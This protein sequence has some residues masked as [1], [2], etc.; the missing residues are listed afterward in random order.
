MKRKTVIGLS[1]TDKQPRISSFFSQ[2][3]HV[4]EKRPHSPIDLTL[5][6]SE[7]DRQPPIKKLKV[8]KGISPTDQWR[9]DSTQKP[10]IERPVA[11]NEDK[12]RRHAEF[13]RVLLAGNN[14]FARQ[15]R[16]GDQGDQLSENESLQGQNDD[17]ASAE[18]DVSD[19][20]FKNL[21]EMFSRKPN[22]AKGKT[23]LAPSA[24]CKGTSEGFGPSGQP[25]TP[26]ELQA[27]LTLLTVCMLIF[28]NVLVQPVAEV[29]QRSPRG[30]TIPVHRRDVHLKKLLSQGH[31]VGIVEQME[32]AALK[33]ASETRNTLFER[34]LTHLYTATTYVDELESADDL[35]KYAAP[36]L[37][38]FT[39]VSE[40]GGTS[41]D[42][43]S[44][45]MIAI[46]PSTG[47][48]VWDEFE[49]E[50]RAHLISLL[51][52]RKGLDTIMR[53]ELETRLVHTR[54]AELVLPEQGLSKL[55]EKVLRHFAGSVHS[56]QKIR[57]ERYKN[58]MKFSVAFDFV[59]EFYSDRTK[60]NSEDLSMDG[61]LGVIASLPQQVVVSL[62]HTINYL[63]S[64]HIADAFLGARYFTKFANRTH[65]LLNASTLANLF[66]PCP[67]LK[68]SLTGPCREVYQNQTDY[69]AKGSL[70]W[71][72]DRTTTKFGARLLKSWVGQPLTD[73]RL[74][75]DRIDA[76]EEIVTS[77]SEK[78]VALR[79]V[80][81]KLP[82]LAKGLC[83]IQYGKCS[84]QELAI[85]L[86]ALKRVATA[87]DGFE[88][89]SL[90]DF[91]SKLLNEIVLS[92]PKLKSP[93]RE[94]LNAISLK[95]AAE[96]KKESLWTD[97]Q[98]FPAL[99]EHA[100][101]IQT[102]ETEL[103]EELKR[104]RKILRMPSLQWTSVLGIEFL[105]EVKK[106][107]NRDH[108]VS[109]DLVS[110]T[111]YCRRYHTPEVKKLI[112]ERARYKE[113]LAAEANKAYSAFLSEIAQSHYSLLRDAINKLAIADCLLS[114]AH[115]ALQDG[116]VRPELTDEDVLDIIDGRHPMV[117]ALRSDPFVP[118]SLLMGDDSPRSII[119]TGPN[120]GG[121]SSAVRMVALI[122]IM[123]QIGSYVPARA[124]K[125][126]M[127]D[128]IITRMGASDELAR[129]RSTFM[130]EMAE[131]NEILKT[132][133]SNSLVILDELGR[134][135]STADGMAIA[136][137]VLQHLVENI[138]SKTL[139]I[140]H[141]PLVAVDLERRFPDDVQNLHMGYTTDNRIDGRR[142][143]TFL[144]Q[145]TD[146][147]AEESFGVECARLAGIPEH[148]L[149]V[150]TERSE[151]CRT[152]IESRSRLNKARR[153]AQLVEQCLTK[154]DVTALQ[155]LHTRITSSPLA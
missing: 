151:A 90:G 76:I 92:L 115:I 39:E 35:D 131:T 106:S 67:L 127:C 18:S 128:A 2:Q 86:P 103:E 130:V 28:T 105:V 79:Q 6:D 100:L 24:K 41:E 53:S 14:N 144:Y 143:V 124:A 146:G 46:T 9:F 121:K 78:L 139:F 132:A 150:A 36:P 5:E 47:D 65:M 29:Y 59:T 72:L 62:A 82:D 22:K 1:G 63:S 21:T 153:C 17:D 23:R 30:T 69:T 129:G 3:P 97:T 125:V 98:R 40:S 155:A 84:P 16:H 50:F 15:R 64:F 141:Y 42:H 11:V 89:S 81:K 137:A 26:A 138:R 25:Y 34:K 126:G 13:K 55:T 49:G 111:K 107:A 66:V 61:I 91:H 10:S 93:V 44:I 149:S 118:N 4:Q 102:V 73:K 135:T 148:I 83:R 43:V 113:L 147:F 31:K 38:C 12:K 104:I 27:S 109:W 99:A 96:G 85:L 7:V 48:V 75:Q 142:D 133:T 33:K 37:V 136:D 71:V 116:Y 123:A 68:S 154:G 87:F 112:Q 101:M 140:T 70:I 145:L 94:Y 117:E 152:A 45:S 120:M 122:A 54:P 88:E 110:S 32:T 60:A 51:F 114:L 58:G 20:A 77:P 134:G 19:E 119:I 95:S 108:P 57:V 52:T 8:G 80:L 56:G 74:L